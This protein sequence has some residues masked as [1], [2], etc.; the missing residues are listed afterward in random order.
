MTIFQEVSEALAKRAEQ[1]AAFVTLWR[2]NRDSSGK[3][4]K[5]TYG[6]GKVD[7]DLHFALHPTDEPH[8]RGFSR[9]KIAPGIFANVRTG[10]GEGARAARARRG[11]VGPF[12]GRR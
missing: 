3:A 8:P 11:D 12:G 5:K 7:R 2:A 9:V 10:Y 1:I 6:H 4:V